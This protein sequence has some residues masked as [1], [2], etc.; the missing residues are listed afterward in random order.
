[1]KSL[2]LFAGLVLSSNLA[3]ATLF[4]QCPAVGSETGCYQLITIDGSGNVTVTAGT[5][6]NNVTAQPFYDL[7]LNGGGVADDVLIGVVNNW[8]G[9]NIT[10]ISINGTGTF[11]FVADPSGT[12]DYPCATGL[13]PHQSASVCNGSTT[14][15]EYARSG[16]TFNVVTTSSGSITFGT[17]LAPGG[18]TW[19]AL[20]GP[21]SGT[22]TVG[23]RPS[24]VTPEPASLALL[25]SAL[26]GAGL[27]SRLRRRA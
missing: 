13:S 14:P 12:N 8:T 26:L 21:I 4:T 20:E 11:D 10:S 2:M 1:M 17:P 23:H 16:D 25:G 22:P 19:F 9:N 6:S 15:N 3:H 7:A 5:L 18:T 27:L 24:T